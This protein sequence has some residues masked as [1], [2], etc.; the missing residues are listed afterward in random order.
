MKI[1]FGDSA[2]DFVLDAFGKTAKDGFI[3]EKS[4]PTQKVLTPRGEEIP[5][6]TI[7]PAASGTP[8]VRL[9]FPSVWK[10]PVIRRQRR[11]P[12]V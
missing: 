7:D 10:W 3:V 9:Y 2:R 8:V 11:M 5:S 12:E 6:S 1:I 4:D